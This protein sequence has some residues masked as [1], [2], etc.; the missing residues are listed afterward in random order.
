MD[1]SEIIA[2][3]FN[4]LVE[5]NGEKHLDCPNKIEYIFWIYQ[6]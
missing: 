2:D 6:K 5:A 1:L 3:H 4:D